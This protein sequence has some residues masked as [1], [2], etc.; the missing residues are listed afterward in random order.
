VSDRHDRKRITMAANLEAQTGRTVA[1]WVA[2]AKRAPVDGFM[3][4]INRLK[5]NHGLSHFQ[6]RLVA[7]QQRDATS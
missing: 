1:E 3:D 7:E 2:I 5:A 6:A 4:T